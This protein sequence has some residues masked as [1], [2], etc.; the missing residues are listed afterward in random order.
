LKQRIL[1]YLQLVRMPNGFT[2]M[3]DVL[4]GYLLVS[5]EGLSAGILAALLAAAWAV[6]SGGCALNDFCDRK[7]DAR[8]RP[9]RPIPSGRVSPT[10][11]LAA[12]C[13]CFAVGLAAAW[14]AGPPAFGVALFLVCSVVLYDGATKTRGFLGP[15]NMGACRAVNLL[16][17]MA[18]GFAFRP[19]EMVFPLLT[20]AYVFSL[21]RLSRYEVT[22]AHGKWAWGIL[23]GWGLTMAGLASLF[24]GGGLAK[25]GLVFSGVLLLLTGWAQARVLVR[26]DV[27][28]VRSGVRILILSLPLLDAAYVAGVRGPAAALSVLFFLVP[29]LFLSRYFQVT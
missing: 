13:L 19:L 20:L 16:L 22:G 10:E 18:P 15:I 8:E 27:P 29:A 14:T 23:G 12:A 25:G 21:T 26:R 24:A 28:A 7:V 4:A 5:G 6:Y 17:G 1:A 2:A 9:E 3:A 11:A